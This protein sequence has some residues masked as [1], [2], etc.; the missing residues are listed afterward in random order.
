MKE[1]TAAIIQKED[2]T[3]I[4][5]RGKGEKLAGKWEFPGGK[6]EKGE[7]PQ[8]CLKR[9]IKE[10][11]NVE[12]KVGDYFGESIYEDIKLMAYLA[13]VEKGEVSLTVH[14]EVKWVRN[15]ELTNFDFAP[16]D[17]PF[18]KKLIAQ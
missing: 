5:R 7:T 6:I 15:K 3:L 2:K 4:A 12:I 17:I 9:E 18:I 14:D 1:V 16:A 13:N 10:E 11:L 8:A